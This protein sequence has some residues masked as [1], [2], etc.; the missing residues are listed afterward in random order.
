M[1][2]L[3]FPTKRSSQ[4]PLS[5]GCKDR[6]IPGI[7][8][9]FSSIADL[10][11]DLGGSMALPRRPP[12]PPITAIDKVEKVTRG[13]R[14]G[15]TEFLGGWSWG[16]SGYEQRDARRTESQDFKP[17]WREE[18]Q[19]QGP[20]CK[21]VQR[22]GWDLGAGPVTWGWLT[23]VGAGYGCPGGAAVLCGLLTA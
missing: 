4:C 13:Y 16:P 20:G 14:L 3:L 2:V 12:A 15:L 17:R 18:S 9:P 1:R 11:C 19:G 6:S 22:V 8:G 7:K 5:I 21:P 23:L 10:Q